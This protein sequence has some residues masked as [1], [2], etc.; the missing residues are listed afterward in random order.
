MLTVTLGSVNWETGIQLVQPHD[1]CVIQGNSKYSL[2]MSL[3]TLGAHSRGM[4]GRWLLITWRE[5]ELQGIDLRPHQS[6]LLSAQGNAD[7]SGSDEQELRR[8]S[9]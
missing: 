1:A 9:Y 8:R 2:S 3:L 6:L 5:Q 7:R 4:I